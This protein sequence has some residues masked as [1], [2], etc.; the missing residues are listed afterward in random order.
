[1]TDTRHEIVRLDDGSI[2]LAF[3]DRKAR[4]IRSE[5]AFK[6][7]ALVLNLSSSGVRLP[8]KLWTALST[9]KP[10]S[11]GTGASAALSAS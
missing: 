5:D 9:T 7:V 10:S 3:Y 6:L 4:E 1:M 11:R 8:G 2:D